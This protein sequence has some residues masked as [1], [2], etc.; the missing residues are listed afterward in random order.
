M[1]K[2]IVAKAKSIYFK[3]MFFPGLMGLFINP[4]YFSRKGLYK[5]IVSNKHQMRGK[6]LDFGCGSKPYRSLFDVQEYIGLDIEKSGHN[7]DDENIDVY[8]DGEYIPFSDNYFDS[9]FSSQ[10]LEHAPNPTSIL[11]EINRVMKHGGYFLVTVP[12]VFDE[13][14]IPYDFNRWT[15]FGIKELFIQNNFEIINMAKSTNYVETLIQLW[16][17]YTYQHIF[18]QKNEYLKLVLTILLIAP[19]SLFGLFLSKLL[20]KSNILYLDNTLVVKK[21]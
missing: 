13:H 18:P 9:V 16:N 3:E 10:V 17:A 15:S 12:F 14:E 5:G 2:K 11:K 20:P 8:Y 4:Y 21:P 7:H 6:L 19:M 1:L